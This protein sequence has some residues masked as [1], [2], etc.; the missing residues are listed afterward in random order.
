[1]CVNIHTLL[2]QQ[3][4]QKKLEAY[5]LLFTISCLFVF[6]VKYIQETNSY[7]STYLSYPF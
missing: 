4:Q 7:L 5:K 3:Q 1:M 6:C 2:L